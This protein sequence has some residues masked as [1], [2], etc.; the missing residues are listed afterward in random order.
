[1]ESLAG[2]DG[3]AWLGSESLA[4][5]G[6]VESLNVGG[7]FGVTS[8]CLNCL[9]EWTVWLRWQI[10]LGWKVLLGWVECLDRMESDCF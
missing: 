4:W 3:L 5:L 8:E 2:M 7:T 10:W 6:W 1:M 9:L